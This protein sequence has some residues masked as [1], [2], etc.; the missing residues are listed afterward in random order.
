MYGGQPGVAARENG[1]RVNVPATTASLRVDHDGPCFSPPIQG[2]R[3][4]RDATTASCLYKHVSIC[5]PMPQHPLDSRHAQSIRA[6]I[7]HVDSG[8]LSLSL[9]AVAART[10]SQCRATLR[11]AGSRHE[12][13]RTHVRRASSVLFILNIPRTRLADV[14]TTAATKGGAPDSARYAF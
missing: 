4:S 9:I 12:P 10:F 13:R 5:S 8:R 2:P 6:S 11:A 1:S 14:S 7:R 3:A